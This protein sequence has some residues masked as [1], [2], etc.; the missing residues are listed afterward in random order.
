MHIEA[1]RDVSIYIH[2]GNGEVAYRQAGVIAI[3]DE[4]ERSAAN[5]QVSDVCCIE[6][7]VDRF[8]GF[9]QAVVIRIKI[10]H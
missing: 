4:L 2:A 10:Y 9:I 6:G 1:Q 3:K 5:S 7:D 8:T